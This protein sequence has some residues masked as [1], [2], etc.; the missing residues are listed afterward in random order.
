MAPQFARRAGGTGRS[1][2]GGVATIGGSLGTR[3]GGAGRSLLLV[4]SRWAAFPPVDG[5]WPGSHAALEAGDEL[6]VGAAAAGE[7]EFPECCGGPV[8]V[9]DG[10]IHAIG[11]DLAAAVAVDRCPEVAEQSGQLCLV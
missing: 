11:V 5:C 9:V 10:L 8:V 7:A 1:I 3:A 4:S 6:G 2:A